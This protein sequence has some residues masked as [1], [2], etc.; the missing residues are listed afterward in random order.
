MF[1][2]SNTYAKYFQ[3]IIDNGI[4]IFLHKVTNKAK[5]KQVGKNGILIVQDIKTMSSLY[6]FL[7]RM[8][9]SIR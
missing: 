4:L 7:S 1:L 9:K 5:L 3:G 8:E 6:E 2:V